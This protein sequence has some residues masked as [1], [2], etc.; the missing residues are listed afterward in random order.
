MQKI[1]VDKIEKWEKEVTVQ[2][3]TDLGEEQLHKLEAGGRMLVDSDQ[4]AF[5]YILEDQDFLH[6]IV[7]FGRNVGY[8]S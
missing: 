7:F 1:D 4:L 5:L 8:I 2:I 3:K 6:Y